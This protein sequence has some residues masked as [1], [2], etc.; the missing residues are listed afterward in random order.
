MCLRGNSSSPH[1]HF[2]SKET[3]AGNKVNW[4]LSFRDKPCHVKW[5]LK[6]SEAKNSVVVKGKM[7]MDVAWWFSPITIK[8]IDAYYVTAV[9]G[10]LNQSVVEYFGRVHG[11]GLGKLVAPFI[12][13]DWRR[14]KEE[15]RAGLLAR[16][17]SVPPSVPGAI[18][19]AI[20]EGGPAEFKAPPTPIRGAEQRM[21]T[22]EK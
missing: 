17:G 12:K 1:P 3:G 7:S 19:T 13:D 15:A 18:A 5:K 6:Q 22:L 8:L 20:T 10:D 21:E 14:V 4:E 2:Q 11:K 16:L 9:P